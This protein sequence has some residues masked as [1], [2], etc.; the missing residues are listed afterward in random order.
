MQCSTVQYSTVQHSTDGTYSMVVRRSDCPPP[1]SS[2]TSLPPPHHCSTLRGFGCCLDSLIHTCSTLACCYYIFHRHTVVCIRRSNVSPP[3]SAPLRSAVRSPYPTPRTRSDRI[4]NPG[5]TPRYLTQLSP[6]GVCHV[7]RFLIQSCPCCLCVHSQSVPLCS[8]P[9]YPLPRHNTASR[10]FATDATSASRTAPLSPPTPSQSSSSHQSS[11]R[12]SAGA[13][14]QAQQLSGSALSMGH[15]FIDRLQN[16]SQIELY[17]MSHIALLAGIPAALVLSPSVLVMPLDLA[18]GL[19]L[20][21]HTHVG[22]VN[23]TDDYVPRPYRA[24]ARGGLLIV[25][26]LA[27]LGLLKINLCGAGITESVKSLWRDTHH[28]APAT[29]HVAVVTTRQATH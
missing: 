15:S 11:G 19:L 22:L 20:P 16:A 13:G 24:M 10:S 7:S 5:Q 26:V 14:E 6:A 21:W 3:P 4:S 9:F 27:T 25:S 2:H 17:H 18:L 28:T 12:Q 29:Q 8:P 1:L 23:V